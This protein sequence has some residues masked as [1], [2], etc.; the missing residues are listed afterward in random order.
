MIIQAPCSKELPGNNSM[1]TILWKEF[2]GKN[3]LERIPWIEFPG[4]NAVETIP[5]KQFQGNN[6]RKTIPGKQF[7]GNNSR[8]RFPGKDFQGNNSMIIIQ[9]PCG[10]VGEL[11]SCL[12]CK[13]TDLI[14]PMS[15][16]FRAVFGLKSQ[17]L[18]TRSHSVPGV[19][20][21]VVVSNSCS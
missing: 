9:T 11:P 10:T 6:S 8:E 1:E 4:N 20:F 14:R 12:S 3:S 18:A 17:S 16:V 19:N 2:P 7:Q 13:M 15:L 5:G 21:S